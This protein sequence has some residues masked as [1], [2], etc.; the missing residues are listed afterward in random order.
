MV[1][2]YTCT[3]RPLT[4]ARM[5]QSNES[6]LWKHFLRSYGER[7][8]ETVKTKKAPLREGPNEQTYQSAVSDSA[9]MLRREIVNVSF[10]A[11]QSIYPSKTAES[12]IHP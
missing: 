11:L 5:M 6:S 1:P 10:S 4:V 2:M 9:D 12:E 7:E 3:F 8:D